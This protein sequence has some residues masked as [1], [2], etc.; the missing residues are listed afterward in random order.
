MTEA[1]I[2]EAWELRPKLIR[3]ARRILRWRPIEDAEDM[4]SEMLINVIPKP[5]EHV[6][7][8]L[9]VAIKNECLSYIRQRKNW[10]ETHVSIDRSDSVDSSRSG[11]FA[12]RQPLALA[13][14]D[15][16]ASHEFEQFE[17]AHTLQ[18]LAPKVSA[19]ALAIMRMDLMGNACKIRLHRA[20]AVLREKA[21]KANA[22]NNSHKILATNPNL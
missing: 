18:Q 4:F 17:T 3:M 16:H 5:M 8:Y 11:A 13:L 21:R 14:V 2:I 6:K 10:R 9:A 19:T 12:L 15:H 7:T 20:R 1:Q 22:R